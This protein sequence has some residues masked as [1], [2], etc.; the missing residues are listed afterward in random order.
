VSDELP[1]AGPPPAGPPPA[2]SAGP[3]GAQHESRGG[4]DLVR[5]ALESARVAARQRAADQPRRRATR[6]V[7][8]GRRRGGY[9]GASPDE[10]DPQPFGSL[11]RKLVADRGWESTAASATVLSRWEALVGDEVAGHCTPVSLRDGELTLAAE[12]TAWATQLRL[13]AP[14]LIGRITAELGKG[15]VTKV[16]VHGP[17]APTWRAGPLRVTG[18]GPRDTYG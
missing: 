9:S 8:G 4:S 13:L 18:R 3:A 5:A 11:V 16:K 12:S 15:V 17:T 2:G 14:K 1:P 10:R 7:A 6:R